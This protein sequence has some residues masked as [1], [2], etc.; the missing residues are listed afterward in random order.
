MSLYHEWEANH[1]YQQILRDI[2]QRQRWRLED[3]RLPRRNSGFVRALTKLWSPA[4]RALADYEAAKH[5]VKPANT[6]NIPS[7]RKA[8]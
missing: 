4:V 7:Q 3:G 6:T 1:R 8:S 5:I 2:E